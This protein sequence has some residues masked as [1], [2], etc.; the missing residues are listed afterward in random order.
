[1][2]NS[3]KFQILFLILSFCFAFTI[4]VSL[5][6]ST[7][8]SIANSKTIQNSDNNVSTP[9]SKDSNTYKILVGLS[10]LSGLILIIALRNMI[11]NIFAYIFVIS[12]IIWTVY[13]GI[14]LFG[15]KGLELLDFASL[16]SGILLTIISCIVLH[17]VSGNS[18]GSSMKSNNSDI[19]SS[20]TEYDLLLKRAKSAF[21]TIKNEISRCKFDKTSAFTSDDLYEQLC[22]NLDA[23]KA[24]KYQL[25]F[26]DLRV[27]KVSVKKKAVENHMNNVYIEVIASASRY[28]TNTENK[29]IIEGSQTSGD[30]TEILC[31]SRKAGC[32][33]AQKGLIEG[34]CPRCGNP[35]KGN[36]TETCSKCKNELR[37]GEFDVILT[38]ISYPD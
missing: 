25:C 38:S 29:K 26:D 4:Q 31:F 8:N 34:I 16:G 23:M 33:V 5:Y 19:P 13:S 21:I 12:S 3:F 14:L 27:K 30:F 36:R 24:E 10:I 9:I 28:K 17:L 20:K 35:I 37:S 6:A 18:I 15:K 32:N 22:I 7:S 1:M 2:S 11:L